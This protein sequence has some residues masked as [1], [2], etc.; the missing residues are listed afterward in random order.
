MESGVLDKGDKQKVQGR[1]SS[2]TGLGSTGLDKADKQNPY[3]S[4]SHNVIIEN[5]MLM[6]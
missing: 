1:V 6:T 3:S 4:L 2:R 5:T